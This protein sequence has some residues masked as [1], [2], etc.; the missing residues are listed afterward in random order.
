MGFSQ[1]DF[2][3]PEKVKLKETDF[4]YL[5][6]HRCKLLIPETIVKIKIC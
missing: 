1:V 3:R 4:F 2:M 6:D 5:K